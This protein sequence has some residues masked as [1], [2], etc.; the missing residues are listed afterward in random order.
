MDRSHGGRVAHETDAETALSN[1]LGDKLAEQ[2]LPAVFAS[3]KTVIGSHASEG[4]LTLN[5]QDGSSLTFIGNFRVE[6][7]QPGEAKDPDAIEHGK[8]LMSGD[9][10]EPDAGA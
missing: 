2:N 4:E 3:G 5:F 10:P 8:Q 1:A 9:L 6:A 7:Y